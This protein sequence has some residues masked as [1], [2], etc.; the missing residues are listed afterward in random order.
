[1]S[2]P[3]PSRRA[4]ERGARSRRSCS[5][6]PSR[7]RRRARAA[8]RAAR[9]PRVEE[10]C[11]ALA[12]EYEREGR[13]F[14]LARVAG[15]YRFQTHPDR[16]RTS[17]GSCSK[18]RTRGCRGPRSRR[19]RSSP[20]SSRSRAR[21]ISRDPRCERRRDAED[22]RSSAATS[23]RSGTS[24]PGNA[25]LFGTTH[26]VPRAARPRLARRPAAARR[27]RSRAAVVEALERG[28]RISTSRLDRGRRPLGPSA[29][30]DAPTRVR[31]TEASG[32]RRCSRARASAR[33]ARARS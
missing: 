29:D 14:V 12:A 26:A 2:D 24:R 6:R 9:R 33:V 18:A 32:C 13:G 7:C 4:I 31:A 19:S 15:G 21:Q 20:T 8:R 3:T 27:L 5:R 11:D 17:S 22:A 16:A 28:L 1:M 25:V 23:R 10:L 30:G